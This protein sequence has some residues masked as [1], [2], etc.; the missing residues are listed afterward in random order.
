MFGSR[1]DVFGTVRKSSDFVGNSV[2]CAFDLGKVVRFIAKK[3]RMV[4]ILVLIAC[5]CL[6]LTPQVA[7][8]V[9][10]IALAGLRRP[11]AMNKT[12]KATPKEWKEPVAASAN[13][14]AVDHRGHHGPFL[15]TYTKIRTLIQ[16]V[17]SVFITRMSQQRMSCHG[18]ILKKYRHVVV[19]TVTRK[20]LSVG[21]LWMSVRTPQGPL[22][23]F[24]EGK[25]KEKNNGLQTQIA[26]TRLSA[27]QCRG[28]LLVRFRILSPSLFPI[29]RT[30]LWSSRTRSGLRTSSCDSPSL[31]LK[32][33]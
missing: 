19:V 8:V 20:Y 7:P 18:P 5:F 24:K 9:P 13:Q 21:V 2:K 6:V 32:K 15:R 4:R 1:R 26:Q 25:R 23:V 33:R 3:D 22:S 27:Y 17:Q 28:C 29:W 12:S 30:I 10:L 11:T 16:V 14:N 31:L